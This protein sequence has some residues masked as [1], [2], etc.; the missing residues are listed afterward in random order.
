MAKRY[1]TFSL[2]VSMEKS[3][4]ASLAVRMVETMVQNVPKSMPKSM[5]KSAE[6]TVAD[7]MA[8]ITAESMPASAVLDF[9]TQSTSSKGHTSRS[10]TPN[11]EVASRNLA[12]ERDRK[13]GRG[14]TLEM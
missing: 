4:I 11:L 3:M 2:V 8:Q 14:R 10:R 12:R 13:K 6:V 1:L 7:S 5:P 9:D